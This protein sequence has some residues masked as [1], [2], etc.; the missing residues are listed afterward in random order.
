LARSYIA[1]SLHP[2]SLH[3]SLSLSLSLSLTFSLSFSLSLSHSLILSS[4]RF[5]LHSSGQAPPHPVILPKNTAFHR[6]LSTSPPLA[7]ARP[8]ILL[9]GDPGRRSQAN[10]QHFHFADPRERTIGRSP[11]SLPPR[12]AVSP[13]SRARDGQSPARVSA[14]HGGYDAAGKPRRQRR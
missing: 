8:S 7:I 4:F 12:D 10:R 11:P 6:L 1:T 14:C 5:A 3:V 2:N 13:K 9:V